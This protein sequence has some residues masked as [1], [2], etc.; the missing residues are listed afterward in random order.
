MKTLLVSLLVLLL[1]P[2]GHAA[3]APPGDAHRQ[4]RDEA[5]VLLRRGDLAAAR[6][7]LES[8]PAVPGRGAATAVDAGQQWTLLAYFFRRSGDPALARQAAREAVAIARTLPAS[9]GTASE[10]SSFLANAGLLSERILFDLPQA[11]ALYDASVAA[12]S[13]NHAARRRQQ[14]ADSRINQR[15]RPAPGQP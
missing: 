4:L 14:V 9:A 15:A 7:K 10:R 2:Y 13:A 6:Q 3:A 12:H 1:A 8:L 5:A 11:K